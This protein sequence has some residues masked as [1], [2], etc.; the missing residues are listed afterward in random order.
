MAWTNYTKAKER[1][2]ALEPLVIGEETFKFP[3][4]PPARFMLDVLDIMGR[5][6]NNLPDS[7]LPTVL[8]LLVG[9][10]RAERLIDLLDWPDFEGIILDL[11]QQ[12]GMAAE[13]TSPNPTAPTSQETSSDDS[14]HSEPTGDASTASVSTTA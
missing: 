13:A 5:N 11:L 9:K 10:E 1:K 12:Y 2:K 7:E 4:A 6:D 14:G 8:K 3:A